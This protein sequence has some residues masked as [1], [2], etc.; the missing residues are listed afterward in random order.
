MDKKKGFT[1]LEAVM[2][3]CMIIIAIIAVVEHTY[4]AEQRRILGWQKDDGSYHL[5][6][7]VGECKEGGCVINERTTN[8]GFLHQEVDFDG[9]NRCDIVVTWKPIVDPTYGTFY[10]V[11]E[12]RNCGGAI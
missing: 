10:V 3:V 12:T 5:V 8:G 6:P 2:I 7:N 1:N 9:D 4:G 11:L